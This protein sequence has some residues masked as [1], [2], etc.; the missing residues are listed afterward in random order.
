MFSTGYDACETHKS[1]Q[2]METM[3]LFMIH[4]LTDLP[5]GLHT[6]KD[7]PALPGQTCC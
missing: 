5:A 7:M 1:I 2:E 4:G 3:R 6:N